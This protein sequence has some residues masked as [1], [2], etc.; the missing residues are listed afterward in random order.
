[1][2]ALKNTTPDEKPR[3]RLSLSG[4]R[5]EDLAILGLLVAIVIVFSVISPSGTFFAAQNFR[6]I[7]LDT[8]ETLV[9]AVGM[10]F[11][12]VA[13]ALDLSV[14]SVVI[15]SGVVA[16]KV[17]VSIIGTGTSTPHLAIGILAAV[18]AAMAAGTAWG[19]INGWLTV[20][21]RIPAFITTLATSGAALGLALVWTK[22]IPV[23]GL[24]LSLQTG[25]G[26]GEVVGIP[27]PVIVAAAVAAI[28]WVVLAR[29]RFGMRSYAIGGNAEA[30]RRSGIKVDRH[31]ILLFAIMGLLAGVVGIID[32]SRFDS[33]SVA[34]HDQ[35]ALNAIAAAVIGGTSLFGG[36]G[37]IAGT[38]IGALIPS[39]LT[40]GFIIM[41]VQPYW[42]QVA[43]AAVLVAAVTIDQARRRRLLR[44]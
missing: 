12:L 33:A 17:M 39:V 26:T 11:L 37:R 7:G 13:G 18:V 15:F 34:G 25:F 27:Y 36:R 29:T 41:S 2:S 9:L 44:A 5:F 1:M 30:A 10:T 21:W 40:N 24:P 8:S 43:V 38:I 3:A 35:D 14:G 19:M 28:A 31:L 42:Q 23:A 32:V 4:D 20:K 22:G 6:N 16:A